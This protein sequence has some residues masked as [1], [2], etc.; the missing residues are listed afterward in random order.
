MRGSVV[1]RGT[2][3]ECIQATATAQPRQA[4]QGCLDVPLAPVIMV[5]LASTITGANMAD[6]FFLLNAATF[7]NLIRPALAESWKSRSF[8][9]CRGLCERLLPAARNYIDQYHAGIDEPLLARVLSGLAF[10]RHIW[11]SLVSEALLFGAVEIPE[12]QVCAETLC[13]LLAP[14]QYREKIGERSQFAPI[15]QA[16][17]GSRDL[18][19]GAAVYRPEFAG[20]NNAADVSRLAAYLV[21]AQPETWTVADLDNLRDVE[22]DDRADELAFAREWFPALVDMYQRA[23]AQRCVLVIESIY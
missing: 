11:R 9:P 6:Y 5:A 23:A 1:G 20:Y 3:W 16:H 10:D 22:S 18:T 4:A 2:A 13:C 17:F 12:F 14:K 19:F 8:E 7:A 15:Q 21:S